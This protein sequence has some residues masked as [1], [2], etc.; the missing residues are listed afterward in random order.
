MNKLILVA[1]CSAASPNNSMKKMTLAVLL[2]ALARGVFAQDC[3]TC[4]GSNTLSLTTGLNTSGTLMTMPSTSTGGAIDPYW[5]LI[6]V[7]PPSVNGS[8]GIAIPNAYTI[9][10]GTPAYTSVWLNI[11][12]AQ[13]LNVI[14]DH[15]FPTN[16][17]VASQ[18]WRFLR[19][20]NLCQ[21]ASVQFHVAHIGDDRDT[22]RI[23]D[24]NGH[25]SLPKRDLD[26]VAPGIKLLIRSLICMPAV[27]I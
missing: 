9:Q 13:A 22:V 11:P 25:Y 26:G 8:G 17:S 4:H 21:D 19:K 6:N 10:F 2:L 12:G 27:A 15:H 16:N 1:A 14:R 18:P 7:A 3:S 24:A 23:F 5:Q 20:F